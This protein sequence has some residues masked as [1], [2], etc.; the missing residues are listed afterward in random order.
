M[1]RQSFAWANKAQSGNVSI[2]ILILIKP[3][4]RKQSSYQNLLVTSFGLL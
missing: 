4:H 3:N 1:K 2:P